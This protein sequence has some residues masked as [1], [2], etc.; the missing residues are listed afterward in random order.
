MKKRSE[1]SLELYHIM[2]KRGYPKEFCAQVTEYLNTDFTAGRMIGYLS[3][4]KTLPLEE[5]ADEMLTILS[6]RERIMQKKELENVNA[7]WNEFLMH[8]FE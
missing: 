5:V 6:D 3:H 2:L 8:G 1:K 4:Y 7:A